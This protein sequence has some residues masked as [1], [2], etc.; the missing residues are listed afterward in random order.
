MEQIWTWQQTIDDQH[1]ASEEDTEV[2]T[3]VM[4]DPATEPSLIGKRAE[5]E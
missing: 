3:G 2:P 1:T 4:D 5:K